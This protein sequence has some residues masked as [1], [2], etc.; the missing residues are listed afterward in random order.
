MAS[1]L[2]PSPVMSC[3]MHE[4]RLTNEE[5]DKMIHQIDG[6]KRIN[7]KVFVS[8]FITKNKTSNVINIYIKK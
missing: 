2:T 4:E 1:P 3:P 7:Y 6:G 5:V 8:K